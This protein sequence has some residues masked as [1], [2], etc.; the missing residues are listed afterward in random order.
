M[1]LVVEVACHGTRPS[2]GLAWLWVWVL[3]CT[4]AGSVPA[5]A[6]ND[7]EKLTLGFRDDAFPFSY[8]GTDG[9]YIGYSVDLCLR[10]VKE[11]EASTGRRLELAS[12]TVTGRNRIAHLLV[13]NID[14]ECG[15]TSN[16]LN[17]ARLGV[18]FSV[19][20]FVSDVAVL[21]RTDRQELRTVDDLARLRP[22]DPPV[23]TTTGT[24]AVR[25]LVE[26]KQ[27]LGGRFGTAFVSGHEEAMRML[28]EGSAT[29]FV[30]DRVLLAS[31]LAA[32]AAGHAG[33]PLRLLDGPVTAD[34]VEYYGL[35]MRD[36]PE[37]RK[38]KERVDAT[39]RALMQS[40]EIDAI[41]DRWF[42]QPIEVPGAA[43]VEGKQTQP[44]SLDIAMTPAL[45]QFFRQPT[46]LPFEAPAAGK[47]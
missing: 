36:D 34:A 13:G 10:V 24:T 27:R 21:A 2:R 18:Q 22:D 6:A 45:R 39:L 19:V 30:M 29:A 5:R 43:R 15:A 47:R 44:Q 37:G 12:F 3:L 8:R 46:D 16:T 7:I 14:I 25:H 1:S 23:I 35:M 26:L 20:T 9:Q 40:G 32:G 17:R 4:L 11:I 33:T 42:R 41:Y 28:A 38:L 31:R